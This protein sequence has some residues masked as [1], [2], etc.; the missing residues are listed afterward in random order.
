LELAGVWKD[1]PHRP[2]LIEL[3]PW[4]LMSAIALLLVEVLERHT[5][6]VSVFSARALPLLQARRRPKRAPIPQSGTTPAKPG[7]TAASPQQIEEVPAPNMAKQAEPAAIFSALQ[8][9][10]E[11]AKERTKR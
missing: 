5:G 2:R 3:A 1:L 10:R 11:K 7:V 8:Q 9:A 4:L 6:L